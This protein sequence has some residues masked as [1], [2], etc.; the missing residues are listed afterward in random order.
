MAR[1]PFVAR[2]L[3][4]VLA[5]PGREFGPSRPRAV[6]QAQVDE[7]ADATGDHQWIHVDPIR[8]AE[9]PY[10]GTIAHGFLVVSLVPVLLRELLVVEALGPSI[11]YGLNK[12]RFPAPVRVGAR[13]EATVRIADVERQ[14][15][16]VRIV[17]DA[18][19]RVEGSERPVCAAQYVTAYF[20]SDPD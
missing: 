20:T 3:E 13:V 19:L 16:T 15:T 1:A 18:L 7:F 11:N 4:E 17:H 8:A 14:E 2:G 6:T 12:V 10:G 5:L 9:G